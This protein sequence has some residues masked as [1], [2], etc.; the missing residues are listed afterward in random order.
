M[1]TVMLF[2]GLA[3]VVILF[4]PA[5]ADPGERSLMAVMKDTGH[6]D[7]PGETEDTSGEAQKNGEYVRVARSTRVLTCPCVKYCRLWNRHVCCWR[8]CYTILSVMH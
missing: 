5:D 4:Q 8:R 3:V 2:M 1:A 7:G 6:G